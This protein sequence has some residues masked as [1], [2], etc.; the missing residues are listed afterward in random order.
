MSNH[1]HALLMLLLMLLMPLSAIE[2]NNHVEESENWR[3]IPQIEYTKIQS[4][5][6][7]VR[8]LDNSVLSE[9]SEN[10]RLNQAETRIGIYDER[11]LR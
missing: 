4:D 8:G 9:G 5:P 11:N 3:E 10:T 6:N 7:S 2:P 1:I